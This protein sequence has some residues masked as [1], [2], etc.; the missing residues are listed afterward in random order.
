MFSRDVVTFDGMKIRA[1]DFIYN[2]GSEKKLVFEFVF[3]LVELNKYQ[4]SRYFSFLL[5]AYSFFF[6]SLLP[7]SCPIPFRL[8]PL[9]VLCNT[10]ED[11]KIKEVV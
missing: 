6:T 1:F 11:Y 7:C 3:L 8:L 5:F 10:Y 4:E 9:L 2:L